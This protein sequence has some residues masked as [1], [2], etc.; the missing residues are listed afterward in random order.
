MCS[1]KKQRQ[2]TTVTEYLQYPIRIYPVGRLDKDSQGLLLLTNQGD[3][4]NRI[5]RAGNFHEKEYLVTVDR[6]VTAP[7]IR[8]MSEGVPI[9]DTV[10]RKCVVEK[11]GKYSFRIILTQGLNRQIRRMCSYFGY[12]VRTLKRVRIMN[13]TL[14][15]L[16]PGEFREIRPEEWQELTQMLK[17]SSN[18]TIT[19]GHYGNSPAADERAGKK[20]KQG[21]K[22]L[23]EGYQEDRE[24]MDNRGSS[25]FFS[26]VRTRKQQLCTT[27]W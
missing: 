9:L 17:N 13:L 7:F 4:V 6:E 3:L 18:E 23:P 25:F 19:G 12:K 14:D 2:E 27:S 21:G 10:T 1:T 22:S 15:G 8:H 24:I 5:M 26:C 20:I 16:K 11:T